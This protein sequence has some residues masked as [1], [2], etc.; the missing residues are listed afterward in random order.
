MNEENEESNRGPD[1]PPELNPYAASIS[2]PTALPRGLR[3]SISVPLAIAL[4]IFIAFVF[5]A[6]IGVGIAITL[7][8]VPA[9]IRAVAS[10]F[11][12]IA[13][14]QEITDADRVVAFVGS[15]GI[16]LLSA[17]SGA[18]GFFFTCFALLVTTK[19][20]GSGLVIFAL[21]SLGFLISAG[22]VYWAT[23]PRRKRL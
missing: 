9:Y 1:S 7:V 11:R 4:V 18:I 13:E 17:I 21:L 22:I 15:L 6:N 5:Y 23:W 14:G 8:T 10:S 2:E 19:G 3:P 16:V 12:K 20:N